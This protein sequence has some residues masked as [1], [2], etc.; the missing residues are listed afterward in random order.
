MSG[1]I[2]PLLRSLSRSGAATPATGPAFRPR[3]GTRPT[4]IPDP[5]TPPAPGLVT[6]WNGPRP[7]PTL[8]LRRVGRTGV[9]SVVTRP[10]GGLLDLHQELDVV[11]G[12]LDLVEQQ[13]DGLLRLER[14]EHPAQLDDDRQLV[15]RQEDLL[16][17]GARRV[18]VDGR[19]DPL[20]RQPAVELELRVPG[21]LELLEDD[22]VHRRAGLDQRRGE[23]G[24]R[25]TVL[26]VAGGAEEALG[27]VQRR[28]VDTTGEDAPAGGGSQV[29]GAAQPGDRVQQD[30]DVVAH[31]DQPL[32]P[33]DGQLRD[34]RVVRRWP[35]E[36][37]GDDL[38]LHRALHVGDLLG[39]LVDEDDH[40]VA[41][42]VVR[43]DRVGDRLQHHRL[44]GL[45]RADDQGPLPLADRHDQVDDPGGQ[46]VGLGLQPQPLLRVQRGE[47]GELRP[48][49]GLLRLE[50]VDGVEP[51][52]RV[53]LVL[54]LTLARLPDGTGDGVAAAQAVAAHLRERDVDVVR[55]GQVARRAD[56]G[57]VVQHVQ[58]AGDGQEDVVLADGRLALVE[59]LAT[60]APVAVAVPATPATAAALEVVVV[61]VVAT[62]V[63]AVVVAA[64]R[65]AAAV[66]A[67]AAVGATVV[68]AVAVAAPALGAVPA[69][70]VAVPA[71]AA[72]VP[73][74]A[75]A[76]A[77]VTVALRPVA[78]GAL[79]LGGHGV[80]GRGVGGRGV[81]GRGVRRRGVGGPGLGRPA[82][83]R[84]RLRRPGVG[85]RIRDVLRRRA[86][87]P[88][89]PTAGATG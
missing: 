20:V 64:V 68:V 45:R 47:L 22:R 3:G 31:L 12:L 29:V 15:G 25:A 35:V 5:R 87:G 4:S 59:A 85:G 83:G 58:D 73:A 11:A 75:V 50:A 42:G 26:D 9:L 82:V 71:V 40:E 69:V 53:V 1:F 81:G 16:L 6:C 66:V 46:L 65:P 44:A 86:G 18:D 2:S 32:G 88:A 36:G 17:A 27:R 72:A 48:V 56:E 78:V 33:L 84:P 70:A 24:Q 60:P 34:G 38:A 52:Q 19:E 77:T 67:V 57:V 43:G 37:R 62:T 13:L 54:A 23:D 8:S 79:A 28:G 55:T 21:A 89:R 10:Q 30:D 51:D 76:A 39:P 7:G 14:R 63:V 80:G 61:L 74:V 41:L 49:P